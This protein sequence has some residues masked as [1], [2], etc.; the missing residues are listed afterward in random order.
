MLKF[1]KFAGINNV[2]PAHRLKQSDLTTATDVDIGLSGEIRR[3]VGYTQR[4][5][6]CHKN[7]WQ[8]DGFMLATCNSDLVRTDGGTQT[9]LY[10][11][12]GVSRVWYLNLPDGRVAFSNGLI[13]GITD[14]TTIT[15][16]GV[17]IPTSLG[18][19]TDVAGS[20]FSGD[21]QYQLTYVRLADNVEG[22]PLYSNPL[23]IAAGGVMLTGLPV[24]A[25]Y[26]INVYLTGTNGGTAYLAGSTTNGLFAFTG[27]V[28]QL[29]LPCRTEF[30]NPMPVGTVSAF[31]RGRALVA[32]GSV[33]YASK[34][35][36]W[37][38]CDMRR[39][40]K[41]FSAPITLIQPVDGGVFVGTTKE[42]CFL[43][44][45]EFDKLTYVRKVD[46]ATV[47]GSG[48]AVRG[49]LIK[50]GEGA[51]LGGA[52]V[53]IADGVVVAGFSDGGIERLT[54]GR[55]KTAVTEVAATFRMSGRTPQ[56]IALPQ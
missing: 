20:L 6:L 31:W 38:L 2:L 1:E 41:Q 13:A 8:A 33:M 49:E 28:S 52:M 29:V 42:L 30:L 55:Y 51:G 21:Y 23:P 34:P 27:A 14:G 35:P 10:P 50:Q 37:E 25:G 15:G 43:A 9:V 48:V 3:R 39:D 5:A 24:L 11:S 56:Y 53:C 46:G 32:V 54:E 47:L 44:G 40:F 19:L 7:L 36:Q 26:K 4:S 12:L 22:S 45:N 17:P 18:A 16:W